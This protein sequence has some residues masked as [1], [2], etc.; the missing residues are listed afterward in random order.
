MADLESK[1]SRA[2]EAKPHS[3]FER[4]QAAR[5]VSRSLTFGKWRTFFHPLM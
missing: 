4:R 5:L 3:H 1:L 2:D